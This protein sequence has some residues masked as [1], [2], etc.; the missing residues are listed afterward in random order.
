QYP[1]K[2]LAEE[3]LKNLKTDPRVQ[4][5]VQMD[6]GRLIGAAGFKALGPKGQ[7]E[8]FE[9]FKKNIDDP[10]T[11]RR[12]REGVNMLDC[13][14]TKQARLD[15]LEGLT[16]SSPLSAETLTAAKELLHSKGFIR[17]KS[18]EQDL[19]AEAMKENKADPKFASS[20]K[21]MLEDPTFKRLKS[22]ER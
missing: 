3:A 1:V 14:A 18:K 12:V 5:E 22:A 7:T 4:G 21:T 9:L 15:V 6:L 13:V 17:L 2:W 20:L 19:I 8:A 11:R 16:K 10:F